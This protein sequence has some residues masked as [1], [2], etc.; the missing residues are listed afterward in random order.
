MSLDNQLIEFE[1][2]QNTFPMTELTDS[3]DRQNFDSGEELW[4]QASGVEPVVR[5]DGVLTGGEITPATGDDTIKV[6][7]FTA[8]IGGQE[9][10]VGA[11]TGKTV[12]RASTGTHMI[13]SVVCDSSGTVTVIQGTASTSFVEDRGE[14][15]GPPYI[16]VGSIEIGQV[17]LSSADAAPVSAQ[18]E[19]F[20][21]VN[22][23]QER[24]DFPV[25][26]T[27][28]VAGSVSFSS[29]LPAIHT[30]DKPKGVHA[31]FA[32]PEF[33]EV[34]DGYDF[35]PSEQAYSSSSTQT[36]SRVKNSVTRSLNNATFSVLL[37]DG[38]TDTLVS[39][40]GENIYFRY[41]PDKFKTQ[42][43]IEQGIFAIARQFPAGG[44][45]QAS[46]TINVTDKGREVS[47]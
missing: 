21:L 40:Q 39:K 14:A 28:F 5:P 31:S 46:C 17:R 27:D 7:A 22:R 37:K 16:P 24:A 1:G 2:G 44:D 38:I 42:H 20:Q 15:G 26:T 33:L 47:L 41:Y 10:A 11:Q 6:A 25:P 9:V 3:G 45:V 35:V 32:T 19:I 12:T 13:N 29:A 30:G 8:Y 34:Y 4:S 36:Y 43:I 23:H 18:G